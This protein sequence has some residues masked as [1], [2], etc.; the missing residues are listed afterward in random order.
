MN[1]Q[2]INPR[3]VITNVTAGLIAGLLFVVLSIS[4]S[5]LIFNGALEPYLSRGIGL[6]LFSAVALAAVVALLGKF[7]GFAVTPQDGPAALLAVAAGGIASALTAKG[8]PD[9]VLP[10]VAVGI[11]L[12]SLVTGLTFFLIGRFNLGNLVR[13]IPYPVVGGFLA[14][15]GWLLTRGSLEVMIGRTLTV[16]VFPSLLSSDM[17]IRWLPGTIFA[18]VV[19]VVIR[20]VSHSLVWP[21]IIFSGLLIF[22]IALFASD[23]SLEEAR[24]AGLLLGNFPS[25]GLWA[26]FTPSALTRV[27][28]SV[29]AGQLAKF[30]PIPLVSLVSFLL[31]ATG[32]EL[33]AK[34]DIDL[35]HE[36]RVTGLANILTGLGGGPIGYP[37][38]GAT[39]LAQRMGA[40]TPIVTISA[41]AV[42]GIVLLFGGGFIS[43]LPVALL[44]GLLL[45]LGLS[46]LV[47][48]VYDAWFKLPKSEYLIVMI[49]L[50][51]I[52]S[53]GFLEGIL[54]GIFAATILFVY[55]YSRV[56]TISDTLNGQIYRSNVD[57]PPQQRETLKA[58]G[59]SIHIYRLQGYLFFGTADNLYS[60]IRALLEDKSIR[61]HY[62]LL[63]F[64]RVHGF[65]SSAVS[66]FTRLHQLAILHN[67]Y[68]VITHVSADIHRRMKLGGF[69]EDERVQFL[70]TLDHGVE[71]CE[72]KL[73]MSKE[74]S[75]EFIR[76]SIKSQL[77]L[78]F[79]KPELIERLL[80]YLERIEVE[81]DHCLLKKGDTPDSMYFIESGRLNVY[82]DTNE[83][84]SIRIRSIRSGTVVGEMGLYLRSE[85]TA[86]VYTEQKSVL[87]RLQ[88]DA[89]KRMEVD[90]PEVA[91]AL[92]EWI[93]GQLAERM[94]ENN[95]TIQA[96]MD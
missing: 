10:T 42:S 11:I 58:Y 57:R 67:V 32:L 89:M 30:I 39:S 68:L 81:K 56:E 12:C 41:A 65:D 79:P 93:A 54:I 35:N 45:V 46:F 78:T 84:E 75:T 9:A 13:F 31:N 92:H 91:S 47:D 37:A 1:F 23:T 90:D 83:G 72:N 50:V 36:L 71:W 88:F 59:E 96:L 55:K 48:W 8:N 27:D 28:W 66:S 33:V 44:S 3:H 2:T 26:P 29:L 19:F 5:T 82:I 18:I 64:H 74:R 61:E 52:A 34:R 4:L 73:L 95:Q 20:R 21:G 6:F 87:F 49:S 40:K 94:A 43:Y 7:H 14:G 15:T 17:M 86:N 38:L 85:R 80:G 63:D 25:G 60:R 77:R 62:V 76:T 51:M 24:S 69:S 53:I 22:Y 70:S 16:D